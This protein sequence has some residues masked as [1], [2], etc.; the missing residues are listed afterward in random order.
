[1]IRG[2]SAQAVRDAEAPALAEGRPL[3]RNA[4]FALATRTV[5]LLRRHHIAVPGA[6]ALVLVGGGNNGGDGLFAAADLIDRGVQVRCVL[7]H[8]RPH[9][10]GLAAARR[11]GAQLVDLAGGVGAGGLSRLGQWADVWVDALAGIGVQGA[12][13][14]LPAQVVRVLQPIRSGSPV[15]PLVV[16][17]DVPSGVGADPVR[18]APPP[19]A[20]G[21]SDTGPGGPGDH[22]EPA[23]GVLRAD[24]TVTMGAPKTSLLIPPGA[25]H[26]GRVEVVDLGLG[27]SFAAQEATVHRLTPTDVADLWPVPEPAD[28]K[29]TRGVVG[30]VA[31][32]PRFPGAGLL[33][34]AAALGGGVGMVRYLGRREVADAVIGAHPEVVPEDGRVQSLVI[35]PGMADDDDLAA[36]MRRALR[37]WGLGEE[38]PEDGDAAV[39]V[40]LD[41]GALDHLPDAPAGLTRKPVV[42]TPHAGELETLL[43]RFGD[44]VRRE[45]IE[46]DPWTWAHRAARRTGTTV[47][48][49]GAI[50]VI[51]PPDGGPGYSQADGTPWLATAGSGDVLA[52]ILGAMLAQAHPGDV[53]AVAAAAVVVHGRAAHLAGGPLRSVDLAAAVPRAIADLL[54]TDP[55]R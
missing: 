2:Y 48:L 34:A 16:A 28:H 41:A 31:G 23:D 46:A 36:A 24:L 25:Q 27:G 55:N 12:L 42:L 8:E 50:T 19:P 1:M 38:S 20:T 30:L 51:A 45:Q 3:M 32:S 49:K 35:G 26:A 11:A 43:R 54:R 47:L 6:R 40:V 37:G 21:E 13:R 39:A 14:G 53:A 9:P 52:G 44:E 10:E 33:C 4:A 18:A 7:A 17:V 15:D 22:D 5:A 29:Y